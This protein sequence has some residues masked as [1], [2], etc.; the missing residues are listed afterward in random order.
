MLDIL[1]TRGMLKREKEPDPAYVRELLTSISGQLKCAECH[2]VGVTVQDDWEDEW[3]DEVRCLGCKKTIDPE[4]LEVFPDTKYCPDCQSTSE[5]GGTPGAE[6]EYCER[7][8]GLLKLVK[9]GG[10]G[11]AGYAMVCSSCGKRG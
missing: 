8:G 11:I 1:Q 6:D 4:R 2:K 10:Q 9:R 7:C 5:S 3:S